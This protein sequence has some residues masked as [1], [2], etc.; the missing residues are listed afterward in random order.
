MTVKPPSNDDLAAIADRYRLGLSPQDIEQFQVLIR[1]ALTSYDLIES[2]YSERL[3]VPPT[4]A[5]QRPDAAANDLGAGMS[6]PRS[7]KPPPAPS[8]AAASR[9]RTTSRWPGSR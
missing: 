6:H 8:P 4:R 5:W 1:G 2:R 7:P 3:P 9:S